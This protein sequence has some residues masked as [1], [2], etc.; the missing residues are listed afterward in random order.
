MNLTTYFRLIYIS[1]FQS[2]VAH[3]KIDFIRDKPMGYDNTY[4][5]CP[6]V[7]AKD[8]FHVSL[9]CHHSSYCSSENGYR[10]LGHTMETVEFG[11]PSEDDVLLHPYS[12]GHFYDE[13]DQETAAFTAVGTVGQIPVSVLEELFAKR[14]GIDWEKTISVESFN[15]LVKIQKDNSKDEEFHSEDARS[16]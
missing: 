15:N 1:I 8:G 16:F 2:G 4:F 7:W 14:G 13:D 3:H 11:Y 12:E 5:F 6:K 9:Q 10:Q